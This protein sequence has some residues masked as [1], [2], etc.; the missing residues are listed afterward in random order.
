MREWTD[1]E[2]LKNNFVDGYGNTF[3]LQEG[4]GIFYYADQ[5]SLDDFKVSVTH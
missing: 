5:L 2:G 4:D 3:N 1:I